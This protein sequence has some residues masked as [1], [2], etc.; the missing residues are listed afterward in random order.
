MPSKGRTG[1]S[2]AAHARIAD[3]R[4]WPHRERVAWL[5]DQIERGELV[6][7]QATTAERERYGITPAAAATATASRR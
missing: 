1:T 4:H 7:R 2:Q 6:I 5:E 3:L